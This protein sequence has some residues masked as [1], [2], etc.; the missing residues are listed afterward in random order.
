MFFQELEWG[1]KMNLYKFLRNIDKY[2]S[3]ICLAILIIL[4]IFM[5]ITRYFFSYTVTGLSEYAVYMLLWI[6]FFAVPYVSRS[7]EGHINAELFHSM[8]SPKIKS[9]TTI[10]FNS[11][12]VI[13]FGI[14]TISILSN[15][16]SNMYTIT[17]NIDMPYPIFLLP[18]FLGFLL[19]T[20][21]YVVILYRSIRKRNS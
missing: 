18:M 10:I 20:I 7:E 13:V 9:I 2:I 4:T 1:V 14:S 21:E 11:I 6:V 17:Q 15:I 16:L 19:T 12:S 8:S 5:V 3:I